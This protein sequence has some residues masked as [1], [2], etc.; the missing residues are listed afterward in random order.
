MQHGQ[1]SRRKYSIRDGHAYG[2]HSGEYFH[3]ESVPRPYQ[4][5]RRRKNNY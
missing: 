2:A 1:V 5:Q 3:K 4:S